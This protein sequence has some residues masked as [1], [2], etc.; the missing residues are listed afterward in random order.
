[1][2]TITRFAGISVNLNGRAAVLEIILF[3]DGVK[4]RFAFLESGIKPKIEFVS[5]H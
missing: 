5:N 1:M 2:D 3:S 4:G